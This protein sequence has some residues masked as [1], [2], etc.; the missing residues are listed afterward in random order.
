MPQHQNATNANFASLGLKDT[1]LKAISKMGYE[2]PTPIQ[3]DTIP[4]IL[5]GRDLL[6][7]AQ[8]GTGK[9]AAFA[10]PL[11]NNMDDVAGRSN[12]TQVLVLA[13][14][15]ELAIQVAEAFESFAKEF[16]NINVLP[17]YGGQDYTK[18]IRALNKGVQVVVGTAGRVMDHMRRGTLQLE[19]LKTLV[20][21]EADEMLRMGF[22]DDVKW[23]LS[24]TPESCQRLLFSATIPRDIV[25][26]VDS[27]LRDPVRIHISTKV[28]TG[29]NIRQRYLAIRG[30]KKI[31]ALD[32]ILSYEETEGVIIFVKTKTETLELAM[33]LKDLGYSAAAMNG[34]MSQSQRELIVEQFK[35]GKINILVA[36]DVAA[37]GLD[38]DRVSHVINYELPHD[39]ESY[40]HRIGRTGRAGRSGDAIS[41]ITPRDLRQLTFLERAIKQP[42]EEMQLPNA[43]DITKKRI[44]SFKKNLLKA[45]EVAGLDK[46]TTIIDE[47]RSEYNIDTEALLSTL[48]FLVQKDRPL[49]VSELPK[50]EAEGK[51]RLSNSSR[52]EP[53]SR[54]GGS[55][56]ERGRGGYEERGR[57]G[58]EDRGNRKRGD[59][60]RD[61]NENFERRDKA[62]Q[63]SYRIEVGLNHGIQIRNIV[64]AIA[65][66]SGMNGS[67]IG[68]IKI[69]DDYS[70]IKLP[71]DT[72]NPILEKIKNLRVAGIRLDLKEFRGSTDRRG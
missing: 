3:I 48:A 42:L 16:I 1:L 17:I 59:S 5:Q 49:F 15:R 57:G 51:P 10:L 37:R 52:R 36:T 6:G 22:I 32:R 35:S 67:D 38:I 68:Q 18:Q 66:E 12:F 23:I 65:N 55:F 60:N 30:I 24:H 64:G 43:A 28:S 62:P 2:S 20:L 29:A 8:T 31:G 21:D 11:L 39:N 70:T 25:Q 47:F 14:T 46:F 33:E 63:T 44:E 69:F 41:L 45:T 53:S 27:Y 54:S 26:I 34:D 56:D 61:S 9:T 72:S 4:L 50:L 13:P 19:N 7:Q 40:I 71:T 58:Y